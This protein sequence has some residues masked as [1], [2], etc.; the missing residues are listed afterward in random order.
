M[1]TASGTA[2]PKHPWDA[3]AL[4]LSVCGFLLADCIPAS[5]YIVLC[6]IL[7]TGK[8]LVFFSFAVLKFQGRRVIG[9][10]GSRPHPR[11]TQLWLGDGT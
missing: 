11:T 3:S 2:E 6:T 7:S 5:V 1:K 10:H 4:H 8:T 9:S